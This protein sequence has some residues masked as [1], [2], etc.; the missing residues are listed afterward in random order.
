MRL[1][2]AGVARDALRTV[3][4]RLEQEFDNANGR[5]GTRLPARNAFEIRID[6]RSTATLIVAMK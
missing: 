1:T 6:I 2:G 4:L 5:R 3:G